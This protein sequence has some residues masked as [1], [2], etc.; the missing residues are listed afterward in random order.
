M[1]ISNRGSRLSSQYKTRQRLRCLP[2][3]LLKDIGKTKQDIAEELNKNTLF[4]VISLCLR[5]V[6]KKR[7]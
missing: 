7:G 3:H 4:S 6:I 5:H 2:E 1:N